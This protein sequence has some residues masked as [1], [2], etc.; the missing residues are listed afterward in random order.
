MS[1]V[2]RVLG[3]PKNGELF[4]LEDHQKTFTV[5]LPSEP[6]LVKS[7]PQK[8]TDIIPLR[9]FEY[10]KARFTFPKAGK[11]IVAL[12]PKGSTEVQREIYLINFIQ[13]GVVL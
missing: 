4:D 10:E 3:G 13:G 9:T 7:P 1:R 6:I 8:L 12:V 5:I 2:Y 11:D